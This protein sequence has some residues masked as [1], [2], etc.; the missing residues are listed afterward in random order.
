MNTLGNIL[1]AV[2][3]AW[4]F[5]AAWVGLENLQTWTS[6]QWDNRTMGPRN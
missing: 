4:L 6:G 5:A 3:A 2:A 1:F